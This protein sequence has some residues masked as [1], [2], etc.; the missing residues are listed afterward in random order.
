MRRWAQSL[1]WRFGSSFHVLRPEKMGRNMS[2][3]VLFKLTGGS[4]TYSFQQTEACIHLN[5]FVGR[6]SINRFQA[7]N[8]VTMKTRGLLECLCTFG[9]VT[10]ASC[11]AAGC[12]LLS[13][14]FLGSCCVG[15]FAVRSGSAPEV[16][17]GLLLGIPRLNCTNIRPG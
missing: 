17:E 1:E 11:H 10:Q 9:D 12:F 7:L 14:G 13:L 3:R 8:F 4:K 6:T 5:K 16:L 2:N 15:L